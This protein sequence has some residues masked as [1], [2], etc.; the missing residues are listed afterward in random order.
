MYLS[1]GWKDWLRE[2]FSHYLTGPRLF[3][4][5]SFA[6]TVKDTR[7]GGGEAQAQL[8]MKFSRPVRIGMHSKFMNVREPVFL[9]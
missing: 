6:T 8:A 2:I 1:W 5:L 7:V 9:I 4:Y 3:Y